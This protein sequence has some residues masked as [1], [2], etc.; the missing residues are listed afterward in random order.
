MKDEYFCSKRVIDIEDSVKD[1]KECIK[2]GLSG[3]VDVDDCKARNLTLIQD[4][5]RLET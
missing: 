2:K 5:D 3:Y 1:C 4:D